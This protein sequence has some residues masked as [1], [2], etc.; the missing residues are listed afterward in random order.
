MVSKL[1]IE[2]DRW[3]SKGTEVIGY[4]SPA[5]NIKILWKKLYNI[6]GYLF[7]KKKLYAAKLESA[8]WLSACYG[9]NVCVSLTTYFERLPPNMIRN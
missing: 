8:S 2:K 9:L 3:F 5:P 7:P 4:L 6:T 1:S